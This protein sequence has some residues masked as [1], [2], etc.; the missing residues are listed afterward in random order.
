MSEL[1]VELTLGASVLKLL[2][3]PAQLW[4]SD[5]IDKVYAELAEFKAAACGTNLVLKQLSEAVAS[6]E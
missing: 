4:A 3:E 2:C 1:C 6:T 5:D